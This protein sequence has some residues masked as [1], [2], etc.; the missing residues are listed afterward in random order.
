[1]AHAFMTPDALAKA[2]GGYLLGA[3]NPEFVL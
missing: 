2:V 1:M 3:S